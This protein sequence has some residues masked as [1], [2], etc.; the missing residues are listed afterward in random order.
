M[1]VRRL[2]VELARCAPNASDRQAIAKRSDP[3]G[4]DCRYSGRGLLLTAVGLLLRKQLHELGRTLRT[5]TP[6]SFK[7]AQP[8]LTVA[9]GAAVGCLVALTS[10]GAGALGTVALVYL[11]PYRLTAAKLVGTDLAHAIPLTLVAGAG[12]L[13]LGN[14]DFNLLVSLLIGSIPGILLGSTFSARAPMG[15]CATRCLCL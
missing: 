10:V 11:Y 7:R 6:G 8:A 12:H 15:L 3:R 1:V 14:T 4:P 2:A 5:A 13:V 9:A